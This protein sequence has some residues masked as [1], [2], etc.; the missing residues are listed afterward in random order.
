M[1][2]AQQ[3][4][5][6]SDEGIEDAIYD[7]QAIRAFVGIEFRRESAGDAAT[8]LILFMRSKTCS[9]IAKRAIATL[10]RI[11][12]SCSRC[13][14]SPI[15]CWLADALLSL[16]PEERLIV[17]KPQTGRQICSNRHFEV[18]RIEQRG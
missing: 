17:R 5:G 18:P 15:C 2:V 16:K 1:Y 14:P 10:P 7:N 8:L 3:C 4:F 6:L 12:G 9:V 13:S 11:P